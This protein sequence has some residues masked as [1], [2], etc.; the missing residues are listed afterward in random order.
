MSDRI[1]SSAVGRLPPANEASLAEVGPRLDAVRETFGGVPASFAMMAHRPAITRAFLQLRS[2]VLADGDVDLLTKRLV[3]LATSNAA[4]CRY[5]Q[6]HT[7][8][9]LS[10]TGV[11]TDKIAAVW[12]FETDSRFS[13]AERAA[14]RFAIAAGSVPNE[15]TDDL[16][17]DLVT[18]FGVEGAVEIAAVCALFGFLNRW[19]DSLSTVEDE[20]REFAETNLPGWVWPST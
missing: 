17:A 18:H 3:A 1:K 5:C 2:A 19:N 8:L 6:A 16:V 7:G 20:V 12:E 9:L 11:E 4:G 14:I 13:N 15:V 10:K